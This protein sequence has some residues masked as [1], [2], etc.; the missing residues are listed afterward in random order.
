MLDLSIVDT[1][2]GYDNQVFIYLLIYLFLFHY[3]YY[4]LSVRELQFRMAQNVLA[5]FYRM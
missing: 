3:Y 2:L 1:T 4:F 5:S